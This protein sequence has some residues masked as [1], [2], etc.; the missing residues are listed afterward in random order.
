MKYYELMENGYDKNAGLLYAPAE[1]PCPIAQDAIEVENWQ[2]LSVELRDGEY[3][4]FLSC[5]AG[6]NMVSEELK[7]LFLLFI[8]DKENIEFFYCTQLCEFRGT[9]EYINQDE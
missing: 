6:A 2:N 4:A 3:C 8:D 5:D 7:N 1:W 9:C